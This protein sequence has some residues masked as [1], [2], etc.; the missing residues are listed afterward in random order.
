MVRAIYKGVVLA[1]SDRTQVVEGNHYFPPE[2]VKT[3]YFETTSTHTSCPWK[4]VAS[5]YT[6][7][8]EGDSLKDAAWTYP[9]AKDAAKA[10]ENHVAFYK[11]KGIEIERS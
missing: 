9:T 4:G 5:Y 2:S 6:I 1:E 8:V 7:T 10:I 3:E 11:S